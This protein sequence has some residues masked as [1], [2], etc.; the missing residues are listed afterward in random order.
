MAILMAARALV[1]VGEAAY[2]TVGVA[3]LATLFPA[4]CAAP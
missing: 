4:R 1:G 2:G 3:L